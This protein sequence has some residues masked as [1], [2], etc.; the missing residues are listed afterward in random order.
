MNFK[1]KLVRFSLVAVVLAT[2]SISCEEDTINVDDI[3][4]EANRPYDFAAPLGNLHVTVEDFLEE[5]DEEKE[6]TVDAKG[7]LFYEFSEAYAFELDNVYTLEN[8][9][10]VWTYDPIDDLGLDLG[11]DIGTTSQLK[12][13]TGMDTE[14]SEEITMTNDDGVRL[15]KM[16]VAGALLD[17]TADIPEEISG[18]VRLYM[19]N[20]TRNGEQLEVVFS[21]GQV[22]GDHVFHTQKSLAGYEIVFEESEDD[23]KVK[24]VR[25]MIAFTDLNIQT[26]EIDPLNPVVPTL[27]PVEINFVIKDVEP[28][29]AFGYFDERE[30]DIE[31]IDMEFDAFEEM[32]LDGLFEFGNIWVDFKVESTIGVPFETELK[33]ISL[34]EVAGGAVLKREELK[35]KE[36][37]SQIDGNFI[38]DVEAAVYGEPISPAYGSMMISGDNSNILD[39]GLGE[40]QPNRVTG[41]IVARIANGDPEESYFISSS[42]EINADVDVKIPLWFRTNSYARA[43]TMDFDYN[44]ELGNNET[45]EEEEK[46]ENRFENGSVNVAVKNGLPFDMLMQVYF[47]DGGKKPV[48]CLF[49]DDSGNDKFVSVAGP[50]VDENGYVKEAGIRE[51]VLTAGLTQEQMTLFG[52]RGVKY[53]V[54]ATISTTSENGEKLVRLNTVNYCDIKL[55]VKARASIE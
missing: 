42:S 17:L 23:P 4:D 45:D 10:Y 2:L 31:T 52:D 54:F 51:S 28:E 9:N 27:T 32:N 44:E 20:V 46:F 7:D 21:V 13:A 34:E 40:F 26:P 14:V 36:N 11:V 39:L 49:K 1:I 15:D 5:Y 6:I 38:F 53:I 25:V 24:V 33:G 30:I 19:P 8:I 3:A 22:A 43:D 47:L 16:V 29:I 55:E 41:D 37:G 18:D 50:T 12:S 48:D 35:K